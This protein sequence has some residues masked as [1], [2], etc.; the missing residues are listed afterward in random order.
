M[1]VLMAGVHQQP[2]QSN[3]L[4][5]GQIWTCKLT[6][7]LIAWGACTWHSPLPQIEHSWWTLC[8]HRLPS[9]QR[10]WLRLWL[11]LCHLRLNCILRIGVQRIVHITCVTLMNDYGMSF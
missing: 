3:Y 1:D 7:G 8:A 6:G 5:E 11:W 9:L 4:V 10:L 2:E